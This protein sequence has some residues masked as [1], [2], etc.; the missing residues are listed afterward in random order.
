[1]DMKPDEDDSTEL[2]VSEDEIIGEEVIEVGS[3]VVRVEAGV[4]VE[5][6]IGDVLGEVGGNVGG[7]APV[8]VG[9]MMVMSVSESVVGSGRELG[10][11]GSIVIESS[12]FE[13]STLPGSVGSVGGVEASVMVSG[14]V[15]GSP[16][17]R[18][19]VSGV[20]VV[21]G[22][23]SVAVE[24][25]VSVIVDDRLVSEDVDEE[26]VDEEKPV[27]VWDRNVGNVSSSRVEN[28]ESTPVKLRGSSVGRTVSGSGS[29]S[30]M[31]GVEMPQDGRGRA[32]YYGRC[33][34]RSGETNGTRGP[35][36]Q[37]TP[38]LLVAKIRRRRVP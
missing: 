11:E 2:D 29:S 28:G 18:V 16:G 35:S 25:L 1:V 24:S 37:P 3:S 19:I 30:L 31:G 10:A 36:V 6:V 23:A 33:G 14:R 12:E 34:T 32:T 27:G 8:N 15:E 22:N 21:D 13:A 20:P 17:V 9:V 38:N 7:V 5:S 4:G 26:D